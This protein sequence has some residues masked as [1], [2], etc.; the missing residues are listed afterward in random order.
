MMNKKGLL[1][2][3]LLAGVGL[4]ACSPTG[5]STSE[6]SSSEAATGADWV[7]NFE[8]D[9]K[10][11]I[12]LELGPDT[13][14]SFS[15]WTG[16][17]VTGCFAV[18]EGATAWPL[19]TDDGAVQLLPVEGHDGFYG[20]SIDW[21]YDPDAY[22]A[23]TDDPW[24]YQATLGYTKESNPAG[25]GV[26]WSYKS[27]ECAAYAYG[28][29]PTMTVSASGKSINLGV[30]NFEAEP[31]EPVHLTNY[32]M[33]FELVDAD[34]K[35]LVFPE[36]VDI[37]IAGS[38]NNWTT[39]DEEGKADTLTLE[40]AEKGLWSYTIADVI[41][42]STVEYKL[43]AV[44]SATTADSFWGGE[45]AYTGERVDPE[46][47]ST[48]P[49]WTCLSADDYTYRYITGWTFPN[50]PADPNAI[51]VAV[52]I[53]VTI[54]DIASYADTDYASLG[55]K[56]SWDWNTIS[57]MTIDANDATKFTYTMNLKP[58]AYEFGFVLCDK[59]GAQLPAGWAGSLL[60]DATRDGWL[61]GA[62]GNIKF[63]VSADGENN[64]AYSGS[65]A[66]KVSLAA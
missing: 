39:I 16:V 25:Y 12:Y 27:T 2:L 13:L 52:N 15:N 43:V 8:E 44:T 47:P 53:S 57:P 22:T 17:F 19:T 40:N 1:S 46:D 63:T 5:T 48:N 64:F 36:Y 23:T 28:T 61:A 11:Y 65:V 60:A 3:V 38:M 42:G 51:E 20:V 33:M 4:A 55:I 7:A 50:L 66:D 34:G 21:N 49:V 58:A 32:K 37:A 6:E 30:H 41:R 9:G 10:M 18:K 54:S 62:D 59:A 26:N 56:G 45:G 29:N 14:A 35:P 31:P 24:A